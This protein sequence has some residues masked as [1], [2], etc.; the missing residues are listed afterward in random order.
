MI[1]RAVYFVIIL[2]AVSF[3]ALQPASAAEWNM[4]SV[5][6]EAGCLTYDELYG[7]TERLDEIRNTFLIDVAV[8]IEANMSGTNER[9]TANAIFDYNDYGY[10]ENADGL[11]LY[12]SENP[13]RYWLTANGFGTTVFNEKS[14]EYIDGEI[15][16]YLSS[17]EY[18]SALDA[19]ADAAEE[20]LVMSGEGK[21]YGTSGS[22]AVTVTT[23]AAVILLPL[24][25]AFVM[26]G[27]KLKDM[28][29]VQK[30][31]YANSN[32]KDG[33]FNVTSSKDIFLY[34][35]VVRTRRADQTNGR[36]PHRGSRGGRGG[37]Y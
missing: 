28:H 21:P 1:K 29:T 27:A 16:P 34:S 37:G 5:V 23:I 6:D 13:R 32:I 18:Y 10:G 9:E 20:L 22:A 14:L 3:Y 24:A 12:I 2:C 31:Q 8:V 15:L 11:L 4:P 33:S 7:L 26:T 36:G 19:Y 25:T 35:S 17:N 30:A